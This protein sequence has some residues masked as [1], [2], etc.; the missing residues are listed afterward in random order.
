M[1]VTGASLRSS[2]TIKLAAGWVMH[3]SMSSPQDDETSEKIPGTDLVVGRVAYRNNASDYY[4]NDRKQ[5]AK[6][7]VERLKQ[8]GIDLNH[9]RFLI[10]QVGFHDIRSFGGPDSKSVR[11][12]AAVLATVWFGSDVLMLLCT[13][14][15]TTVFVHVM[16]GRG[17]ADQ[18]HGPT[19][20][21]G[22]PV[23]DHRHARL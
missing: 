21:A 1:G 11:R 10:L 7:V 13:F 12:H 4:I 19:G 6:V 20:A 14:T 9:N 22:L 23:R 5:P 8:E 15:Q 18:P 3:D 17:G 2:C 16:A